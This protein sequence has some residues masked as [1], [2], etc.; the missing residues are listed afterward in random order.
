MCGDVGS[1]EAA[2]WCSR[3]CGWCVSVTTVSIQCLR[4][5]HEGVTGG[6]GGDCGT[7]V[8]V[9]AFTCGTI[10]GCLQGVCGG[11]LLSGSH[12]RRPYAYSKH[13]YLDL[14]HLK[15]RLPVNI[16]PGPPL[17]SM[18]LAPECHCDRTETA[19][20]WGPSATKSN[21]TLDLE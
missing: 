1:G 20:S 11:M 19:A 17:T 4:G 2:V 21:S 10:W 3:Q 9:C 7:F 13:V 12:C 18:L 5:V 16:P 6:C 14:P 8:S 15:V